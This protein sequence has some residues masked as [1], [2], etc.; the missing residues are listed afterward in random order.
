MI[1]SF[2]TILNY[3]RSILLDARMY[4]IWMHICSKKK[5]LSIKK[6]FIL[7]SPQKSFT[8][9]AWCSQIQNCLYIYCYLIFTAILT[10][11]GPTEVFRL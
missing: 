5:C 4:L 11:R 2:I 10:R 6:I 7:T 1:R 8:P 3:Y 9:R